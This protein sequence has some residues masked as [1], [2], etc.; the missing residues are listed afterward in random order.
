MALTNPSL[1]TIGQP[2]ATEDVDTLSALTAILN[3]LNGNLDQANLKNAGITNLADKL[4]TAE[5]ERLGLSATGTVRRGTTFVASEEARTG[6]VTAYDWMP[7]PDRVSSVVVPT[8]GLLWVIYRAAWKA[9]A[10][11]A[12]R[13]A[14]FVGSQQVV[15]GGRGGQTGPEAE[16][17]ISYGLSNYR[18]LL[19]CPAGVAS[20]ID[21]TA[22]TPSATSVP[23][24]VGVALDP[25]GDSSG[26]SLEVGGEDLGS[27]TG[28]GVFGGIWIGRIDPGTYDV[29]VKYKASSGSVTAKNRELLVWVTS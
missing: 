12:G 15:T 20:L 16:A 26:L 22:Y 25:S 8:N 19:T 28:S 18:P 5:A 10:A 7:T 11:A 24:S 21:E 9:S 4:S 29:G 14:L 13:A 1:P 23:T 17:A 27:A 6:T 2:V 3:E